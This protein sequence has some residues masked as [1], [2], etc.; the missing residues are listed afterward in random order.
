M[1]AAVL[2]FTSLNNL[3]ICDIKCPSNRPT[4]L[5]RMTSKAPR[6]FLF[7]PFVHICL[8]TILP[9]GNIITYLFVK[10]ESSLLF[11]FETSLLFN[12]MQWL[13]VRYAQQNME[14]ITEAIRIAK[15]EGLSVSLDLASFEVCV[16]LS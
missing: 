3:M 11:F 1:F 14:Q 15:Q 7:S 5:E 12:S 9:T 2:H 13:V 10:F 16:H 4:S 6:C 8:V